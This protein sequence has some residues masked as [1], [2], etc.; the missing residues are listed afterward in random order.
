MSFLARLYDF[1]P[2]T[3]IQSSQVDAEF[4][5]LVDILNGT[6]TDTQVKLS[7]N[8]SAAGLIVNNSGGGIIASFQ[9]SAAEK[10]RINASGQI[11]SLLTTGTAPLVVASTTKVTNLNADQLDGLEAAAFALLSGSNTFTGANPVTTFQGTASAGIVMEDTGA[12]WTKVRALMDGDY[13]TFSRWNVSVW[14]AF[15]RLNLTNK[16]VQVSSDGA[17]W[18]EVANKTD[19]TFWTWGV[20][21]AGAV[22]T[23]IKQAQWVVPA[24][25][26]T[27]KAE[28]IRLIYQSATPTG[29]TTFT[30]NHRNSSGTLQNTKSVSMLSSATAGVVYDSD[31]TPDWTMSAGDYL[32]AVVDADG[33]HQDISL[34]VHGT[35][36]IGT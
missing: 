17:T 7:H 32:E 14:E 4:A 15:L 28:H 21:Y 24:A 12:T 35:Q 30:I 9:V 2:S 11:E 20:F 22:D 34:H 26:D 33:G 8:T 31:I 23:S 25:I 16:K 18:N 10:A 29:T 19:N 5:Q 27:V 3:L 13:L 6:K 1:T 36:T